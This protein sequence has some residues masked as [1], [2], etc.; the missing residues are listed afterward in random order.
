MGM[1]RHRQLA[2]VGGVL[3]AAALIAVLFWSRDDTPVAAPAP[4]ASIPAVATPA[5]AAPAAAAPAMAAH[6]EA[7]AD[8]P[9]A[10]VSPT[11]PAAAPPATPQAAGDAVAEEAR[12]MAEL[13]ESYRQTIQRQLRENDIDARLSELRCVEGICIGTLVDG[14]ADA[15]QRW[16][17]VM[18]RDVSTGAYSLMLSQRTVEGRRLLNFTVNVANAPRAPGP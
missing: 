18:R 11:V 17:E 6:T 14:T 10:L 1:P 12:L 9:A 2:V 8:I 4:A 3:T 16:G 5:A 15:Y 13:A 7:T